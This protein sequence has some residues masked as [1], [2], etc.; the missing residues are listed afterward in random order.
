MEL[1]LQVLNSITP[2]GSHFV[3]V[4][5]PVWV[6]SDDSNSEKYLEDNFRIINDF[7]SF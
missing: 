7:I 2:V 1:Q 5:L 4:V 3:P 6:F